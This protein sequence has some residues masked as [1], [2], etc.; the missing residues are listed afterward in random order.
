M[1]P[2]INDLKV[3]TPAQD[4]ELSKRFYSALGFELTDAWAGD[5]DCRL[6]G[7]QFRLQ[8]YYVKEWANNFMM[9]FGVDDAQAWY[10]HAKAVIADEAFG[11]ARVSEPE[12]VGDSKIVHVHDPS[13]VLLIFVE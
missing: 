2:S 5:V 4:F 6:G 10:D 8:K 11:P 3:Y 1:R 13:G 9:L 12:V 7:A